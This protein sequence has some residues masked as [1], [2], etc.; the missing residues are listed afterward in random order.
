M[1]HLIFTENLSFEVA[2][3]RKI[4][5]R[6]ATKEGMDWLE[7]S[8]VQFIHKNDNKN[9][10]KAFAQAPRYL[11]KEKIE[12]TTFSRNEAEM[13]GIRPQNW[14][15]AQAARI[16]MLVSLPHESIEEYL[17]ILDELFTAADVEELVSF[18]SALPLL[19]YPEKH[20]LR[21]QEGIRSNMTV[22]YDSVAL[23]NPY[24]ADNFDEQAWNQMVLKAVFIGRPLNRIIKFD[25]RRNSKLAK[26]LIDYA[27][28]RWAANRPVSP[29]LWRAVGPFLTEKSLND[30]KKLLESSDPVNTKAAALACMESKSEPVR[31]LLQRDRILFK[32]VNEEQFSWE[33][34]AKEYHSSK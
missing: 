30:L 10:F 1:A 31:N 3:L 21:A 34:V 14:T 13:F 18:Y 29:E 7:E 20:V 33:S 2:Y 32:A 15:L 16:L 28:E 23:D 8:L 11:G 22:V 9:I 17:E 6:Q 12:L 25:E 26:M 24:P 4:I 27:H 19:P 5:V